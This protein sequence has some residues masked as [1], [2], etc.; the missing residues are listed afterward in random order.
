MNN[1]GKTYHPGADLC[2]E[3]DSWDIKVAS[4]DDRMVPHEIT[5]DEENRHYTVYVCR[6]CFTEWED[7]TIL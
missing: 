4:V 3:C 2:P 7:F 1:I 5:G 6:V